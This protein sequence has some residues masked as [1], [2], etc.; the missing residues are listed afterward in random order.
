MG[1]EFDAGWNVPFDLKDG[2]MIIPLPQM[3]PYWLTHFWAL[4]PLDFGE[5]GSPFGLGCKDVGR[6]SIVLLRGLNHIM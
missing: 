3:L 1:G 2:F 4:G 5:E 6:P